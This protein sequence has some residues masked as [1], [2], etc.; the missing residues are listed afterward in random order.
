MEFVCLC[1]WD[2]AAGAGFRKGVL[3]TSSTT[4][5]DVGAGSFLARFLNGAR[6]AASGI[7]LTLKSQRLIL[8]SL[9]PMLVQA[10]IF[11]ALVVVGSRFLDDVMTRVAPEQGHWYSFIGS[12][13]YVALVVLLVVASVI[14]SIFIASVVCDPFYDVLSEATESVLLGREVGLP[15]SVPLVVRG[16]VL[17]LGATLWRLTI[18]LAVAL[19]LWLIGLTGVGSIIAVPASLAWSWMFVALAFLSRSMARHYIPG[20]KRM[21]ALFEQ[22]ACA[23]GFGAVGWVMAYIPLTAPFLVVGA[24]RM[25]LALAA[26]D[27]IASNLTPQDKATL[28][29]AA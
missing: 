6:F 25:Y 9:V 8:W 13:L 27:R 20:K 12:V 29:G 16:I 11:A 4:L 14:A 21:S 18:F 26:H 2:V 19:P 28:R 24:T 15:F 1:Q 5:T 3:V 7:T 10:A 23:L 17:E 22:K